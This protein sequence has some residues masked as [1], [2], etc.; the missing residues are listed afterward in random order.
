ML[1]E[2]FK[3]DL[4]IG[5]EKSRG[6]Y[7][8]FA[9]GQPYSRR[10][11]DSARFT[12]LNGTWK[13]T[14]YE[15]VTDAD[16]FWK[17][18]GEKDVT[19][20]SCV[21]Y[22]GYDEFQY[23]NVR[24]PFPYDPPH[25]PVKNPAYHHSRTF[26]WTGGEEEKAYLVFEGVDSCFYL[27]IN[28][29]FVGFS[30][31]S[32]RI[33]EFDVTKYLVE[34]EN[35]LDV[36]VLKWCKGSYLEDQDKFRFTGIFR[37]VYLLRRPKLHIEDYKITTDIVDG[38]GIVKIENRGRTAFNVRFRGEERLV[39]SGKEGV[40]TVENPKLWSAEAPNLY[41]MQIVCGEELVYERVGICTSKVVDGV[42]LFNGKPIKL[43][44][45][46]RHDFHPTKGAAVSREDMERDIRL[47]KSLNVNALRTSHY[48]ASP[49]LYELC[50]EYGL[51]V[52]SE[53]DLES[54]GSTTCGDDVDFTTS[55]AYIA[56]D[57]R[58][59]QGIIDR[60]ICNIEEHKNF[61]CVNIWSL[62]NE[63]GWGQNYLRA[64]EVVRARDDRPV[65]YEGLFNYDK[66]RYGK[67]GYYAAPVDMV[68]RMYPDHDWLLHGY[69]ENGKWV[70]GYLDDPDETRPLVLCEYAHAMGNSPG[71]LKEYWE[72]MESSP[73]F[74]G[75]YIW[76]WADHG[77]R[78]QQ[79]EL[80]Y[81][82]DFGEYE[83]D[84]NFC[85]DGIV[86]ADRELKAGTLSM[87]KVYEPIAFT[88]KGA[89]L[90]IFNK[91]YFEPFVGTVELR[92][93]GESQRVEVAIAPR[94]SL[95]MDCKEGTLELLAFVNGGEVARE[96]FYEEPKAKTPLT[97]TA[98][99]FERMGGLTKVLA[100]GKTYYLDMS[101]GELS[102]IKTERT[103]YGRVKLNLWRAPMDNDRGIAWRWDS[104]F[105]RYANGNVKRVTYRKSGITFTLSVGSVCY[106]PY[107]EMKLSYDFY[108]EGVELSVCYE[109]TQP[110]YFEFLPRIGFTWKLTSDYKQLK[111]LAYGPE[112]TYAD[113]VNFAWKGEY[114]GS[115]DA[116]YYPYPN[117]QESGSHCGAD[118]AEI[119]NGERA[120]R[121]EGMESFSAIPYAAEWLANAKHQ[122]ELPASDGTYFNLDIAM[123]GT[124]TGACG[125]LPLPPYRVP[126]KG[127]G[128]IALLFK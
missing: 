6:Y 114:E 96:Q 77:V 19:V 18:E 57:E 79:E 48:P 30:Q 23:T 36:L 49:L 81:G 78:Y 15:S 53:T 115:V 4:T 3:T 122:S 108:A 35:K 31:I 41:E 10:R 103:E 84:G 104:K 72:I 2:Y 111:Y 98:V 25:I 16:G 99:K 82:G 52:M 65:H 93:K 39:R 62:G 5:V 24:Y 73:R 8:P 121:A 101:N 90:T 11:E 83:H 34:G 110:Q 26:S 38:N 86:S 7:I 27:Y 50:N 80:R 117:P 43:Y 95:A 17:K 113:C 22:F 102:S 106:R 109:V 12:S 76:E 100:G 44:G 112:E 29:K 126:N 92:Q 56:E 125:P 87:K 45:V 64:I 94:E 60:Q 46:N 61:A 47:M 97:A 54:H 58:F 123:S 116:Q 69:E 37:D 91:N 14:A 70:C 75:A 51:Y 127:K 88:R 55:F 59:T 71:G 21:Q 66:E 105:L 32:H 28:G 119:S 67:H 40:F 9:L 33:S 89:S 20:P 128:K 74:M 118:W 120:V 63:A 68:S 42:Y 13:I 124:G 85:M 107:M 1:K